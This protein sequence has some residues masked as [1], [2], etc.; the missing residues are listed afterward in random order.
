MK[1]EIDYRMLIDN[2]LLNVIK[3][4]LQ[5]IEENPTL[6]K[7]HLFYIDFLTNH[8][9]TEVPEK[10]KIDYPE[11]MTI[12]I[13][14]QFKHLKVGKNHFSIVLSFSGQEAP[15]KIPYDAI[16]HFADPSVGFELEFEDRIKNY[17]EENHDSEEEFF[18]SSEN[19]E[20]SDEGQLIELDFNK[21]K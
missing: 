16:T 3:K 11:T 21:K 20:E 7:N 6:T 13:Q 10:L 17:L 14:N 2:S 18:D 5:A 9:K 8:P 19:T 15:L 1:D 4:A 12:V